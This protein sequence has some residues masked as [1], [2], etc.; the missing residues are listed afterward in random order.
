MKFVQF[1]WNN[2]QI[3]RKLN[4]RIAGIFWI[5]NVLILGLKNKCHVP[6][7]DRNYNQETLLNMKIEFWNKLYK[8]IIINQSLMKRHKS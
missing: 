6:C 2:L 5:Q 3:N 8:M 7:V 1:V 4:T